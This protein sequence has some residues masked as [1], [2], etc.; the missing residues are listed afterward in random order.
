MIESRPHD[1]FK[2]G[3]LI[4]NTYRIEGVLGRGG[5]SEVYRA[6]SEISGRIVAMKVLK[7]EFAG[8]EDYLVLMN[9]EEAMRDIRHDAVVRYS[10]NHRTTEGHVY[11]IMDYVDGPD[12]HALLKQ[13]GL[14]AED[15]LLICARVASGLAVAHARNI[16]HR[17]LSP[18][19]IILKGGKPGHAVIIDFGIA[20]D[21]SP[22]AETIT[23]GEFAGKYAYA[24]PEQLNGRADARSDIYALGALLLA[25]FRGMPPDVGRNPMEVLRRKGEPLDT[26]G[27]PEPLKSLIDRMTQPDPEQRLQSAEAVLDAIDPKYLPD[28]LPLR[29]TTLPPQREAA[30]T[31]EAAPATERSRIRGRGG[32]DQVPAR[33]GRKRVVAGVAVLA[34]AGIGVGGYFG[35]V[36]GLFPGGA[37]LPVADPYTLVVSR[38]AGAAPVAEGHVPSAEVRDDLAAILAAQGGEARLELATGDIPDGWGAGIARLIDTVIALEEWQISA[39]GSQIEVTGIAEERGQHERVSFALTAPLPGDLSVNSDILL[40]P[41]RLPVSDVR[42]VLAAAAEC[43]PLHLSDAP[44]VAY[45]MGERISVTGA[46]EGPEMREVIFDALSAIAGDRPVV[47]DLD[48]LNRGLCLLEGTLAQVPSGDIE[49]RF[50]FGDRP[51]DNP[52]GRY[53]VGENPVIDI[54]LPADLEDGHLWVSIIDVK[55]S[56]FHLLPNINRQETAV[57]ALRAGRAE[58]LPVRVAYGVE[59]AQGNA[60]LAFLVDDTALGKNRILVLHGPEPLFDELRPT[61]ESIDSFSE[62]L[63]TAIARFTGSATVTANSRILVSAEQE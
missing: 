16:F 40:G 8:N 41:V 11:L 53:Y 27:V 30:R 34:L 25:S 49:M 59:E 37:G 9:R 17:D 4:N 24:A 6:R 54:I 19:N 47:L 22:G 35:G 31:D 63:D 39:A 29:P 33:S 38:A 50:G 51:Q 3:E 36:P 32:D 26:E 20:K 21:D 62:V 5:T 15:L 14:P 57:S 48:V 23:G 56:V 55:G 58:T 7:S 60:R 10:E 61:S 42:E 43:G 2:P 13:G 46:I 12:L 28:D 52:S 45:S 1:I 18:D 44:D